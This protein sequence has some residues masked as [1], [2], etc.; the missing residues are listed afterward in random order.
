MIYQRYK[1]YIT[2]TTASLGKCGLIQEK[3][4]FLATDAQINTDFYDSPFVYTTKERTTFSHRDTDFH[5]EKEEI[6]RE[7]S[8][9]I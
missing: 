4:M 3:D 2:H 6:F 5:R 7:K 1:I 9:L 8:V